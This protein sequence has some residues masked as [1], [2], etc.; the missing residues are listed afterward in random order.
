MIENAERA[1]EYRARRAAARLGL[2]LSKD[3]HTGLWYVA[4]VLDPGGHGRSRMLQTSEVGISL[5]LAEEF[6]AEREAE[7]AAAIEAVRRQH[8]T[9][10]R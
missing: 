6:V 10:T 5:E 9:V 8:R 3:R 2:H 1:R 7:E 4:K